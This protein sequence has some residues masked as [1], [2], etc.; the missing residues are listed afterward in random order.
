MTSVTASNPALPASRSGSPRWRRRLGRLPVHFVVILLMAI[1]LIPTIGLFVN[2]FRP[3]A[4]V[5]ATTT[6]SRWS[7]RGVLR[8]IG[9][10]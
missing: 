1:W 6:R 4:A 3:A 8:R 10:S 7:I 5:Q 9:G 2:S